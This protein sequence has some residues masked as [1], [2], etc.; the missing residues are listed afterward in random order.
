[1]N[2]NSLSAMRFMRRLIGGYVVL[3]MVS[4]LVVCIYG[5]TRDPNNTVDNRAASRTYFTDKGSGW[6][7]AILKTN[8]M[9]RVVRVGFRKTND[10][11]FVY[12]LV[13]DPRITSGSKVNLTRVYFDDQEPPSGSD[14][15]QSVRYAELSYDNEPAPQLEIPLIK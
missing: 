2:E 8:S 11:Y 14:N 13:M 10:N 1:M 4:F 12:A 5:C 3:S 7:E 15:H 9:A 6:V